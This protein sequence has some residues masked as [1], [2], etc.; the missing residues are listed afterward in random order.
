MKKLHTF[1]YNE[2][3]IAALLCEL[4]T[5]QG[6]ACLLRNDHLFSALGEIPLLECFPELWVVDD[7][8]Y[9]RA[10]YLLTKWLSDDDADADWHCPNC[11]EELPGVFG[12][13]WA[14]GCQRP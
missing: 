10:R 1:H 8:V 11:G 6:V 12:A 2:R 7:E 14:C 3:A 9:P 5:G 13:C 4:L